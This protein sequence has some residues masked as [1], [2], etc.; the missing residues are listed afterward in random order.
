M[1]TLHGQK[2]PFTVLLSYSSKNLFAPNIHNQSVSLYDL[3]K[4]TS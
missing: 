4:Q 3:V 2:T 1:I